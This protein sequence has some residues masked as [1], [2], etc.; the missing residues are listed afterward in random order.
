MRATLGI[1]EAS[2]T[3][4][5][6]ISGIAM[7]AAVL[8]AFTLRRTGIRIVQAVRRVAVAQRAPDTPMVSWRR[9]VAFRPV[10]IPNRS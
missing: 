1:D 5:P 6:S 3:S 7:S 8:A 10:P 2:P 4:A 9:R